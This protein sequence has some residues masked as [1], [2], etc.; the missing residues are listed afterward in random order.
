MQLIVRGSGGNNK[1]KYGTADDEEDFDS[2]P[3]PTIA[4]D[5]KGKKNAEKK[6]KKPFMFP[7]WFNYIAWI[8]KF[9][10]WNKIYSVSY[11]CV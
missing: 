7:Q 3:V 8:R 4:G 2:I 11:G 6:R 9:Y 10:F 5:R 1:N